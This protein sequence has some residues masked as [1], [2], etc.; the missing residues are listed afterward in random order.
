MKK[1]KIIF[2]ELDGTLTDTISDKTS[3]KSFWDVKFR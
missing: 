2:A 1:Y 3:I